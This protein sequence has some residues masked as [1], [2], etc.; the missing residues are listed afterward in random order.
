MCAVGLDQ[1]AVSRV[2]VCDRQRGQGPPEA[3]SQSQ[4]PGRS[5]EELGQLHCI[6]QD[7]IP[8]RLGN[9]HDKTVMSRSD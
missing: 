1:L 7:D 5:V 2:V 6:L 4:V 3:L 9:G 8:V